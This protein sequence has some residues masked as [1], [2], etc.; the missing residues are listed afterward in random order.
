M[1]TTQN[2]LQSIIVNNAKKFTY[3]NREYNFIPTRIFHMKKTGYRQEG[4]FVDDNGYFYGKIDIAH[5]DYLAL[6]DSDLY[7]S[8]LQFRIRN[9]NQEQASPFV[10]GCFEVNDDGDDE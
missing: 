1:P 5:P 8:E 3:E 10:S 9:C 2:E 6:P 7:D 4:I